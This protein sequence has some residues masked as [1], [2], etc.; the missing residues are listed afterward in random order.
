MERQSYK[1]LTIAASLVGRIKIA[2]I[3]VISN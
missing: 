3:P 2:T 1:T